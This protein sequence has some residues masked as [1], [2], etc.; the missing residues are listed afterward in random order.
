MNTTLCCDH[1]TCAK[2]I[3]DLQAR[4]TELEAKVQ[5]KS[6]LAA[7]QLLRA[8]RAEARNTDLET[9]LG[10]AR[11]ALPNIAKLIEQWGDAER[12]AERAEAALAELRKLCDEYRA[13]CDPKTT[14]AQVAEIFRERLDAARPMSADADDDRAK[15]ARKAKMTESVPSPEFIARVA[16]AG[17]IRPVVAEFLTDERLE[18]AAAMARTWAMNGDKYHGDLF[19]QIILAARWWRNGEETRKGEDD[20]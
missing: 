18:Y 17:D 10:E 7:E 11:G 2:V 6:N 1:V 19:G 5:R 15:L 3:S 14:Q 13:N 12:R 8:E 4:I 9:S 16:E 20:E